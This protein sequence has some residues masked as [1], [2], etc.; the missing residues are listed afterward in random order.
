MKIALPMKLEHIRVAISGD[1]S[2]ACGK[3]CEYKIKETGMCRYFKEPIRP[4][5]FSHLRCM[6]CV[7]KVRFRRAATEGVDTVFE[8]DIP[9]RGEVLE[10]QTFNYEKNFLCC[11]CAFVNSKHDECAKFGKIECLSPLVYVRHPDCRACKV[12]EE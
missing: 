2:M 8:R 7:V 5:Y 3:S 11:G 6:S 12:V 1:D 10:I 9:K 4:L